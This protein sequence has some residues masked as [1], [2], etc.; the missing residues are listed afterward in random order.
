MFTPMRIN[1]ARHAGSAL[2]LIRAE[3]MINHE[4]PLTGGLSA[5]DFDALSTHLDTLAI[6]TAPLEMPLTA[7][8]GDRAFADHIPRGDLHRALQ[9]KELLQS[10]SDRLVAGCDLSRLRDK[11]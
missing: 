3:R 10:L 9:R 11:L 1:P 4:E 6:G 8:Q 2:A 5:G 7:E